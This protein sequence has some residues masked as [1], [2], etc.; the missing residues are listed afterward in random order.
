MIVVRKDHHPVFPQQLSITSTPFHLFLNE[1]ITFWTLLQWS[2]NSALFG[3]GPFSVLQVRNKLVILKI[4][5][6]MWFCRKMQALV[7]WSCNKAKCMVEYAVIRIYF[8]EFILDELKVKRFMF[9]YIDIKVSWT[10]R[11]C[12][13]KS[14]LESKTTISTL[15]RINSKSKIKLIL[16]KSNQTG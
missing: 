1:K 8:V 2:C 10:I 15:S 7:L 12:K 5:L 16:L 9:E 14:I 3:F 4:K 6:V 13:K 11:L